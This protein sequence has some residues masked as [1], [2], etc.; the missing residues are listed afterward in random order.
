MGDG[1]TVMVPFPFRRKQTRDPRMDASRE[2]LDDSPDGE[3]AGYEI[4]PLAQP[5]R[6][7]AETTT[8]EVK[9][10]TK[11]ILSSAHPAS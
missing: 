1:A 11:K 5:E 3:V 6:S 7:N 10:R 2:T 8:V 9:I 4:D